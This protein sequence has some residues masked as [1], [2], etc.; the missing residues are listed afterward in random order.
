MNR[1][2]LRVVAAGLA[3]ASVVLMAAVCAAFGQAVIAA[4]LSIYALGAGAWL[5]HAIERYVVAKRLNTVQVAAKPLLPVMA[6]IIGLTQAVVRALSDVADLQHRRNYS[7]WP[8]RYLAIP[9]GYR[10]TKSDDDASQ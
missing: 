1:V 2:R 6:A 3:A 5:C 8:P 4:A 9:R 7:L 10:R